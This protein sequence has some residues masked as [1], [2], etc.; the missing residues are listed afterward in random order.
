MYHNTKLQSD[1]YEM[2]VRNVVF[3]TALVLAIIH[4]RTV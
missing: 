2:L 4:T 3:L 1:V